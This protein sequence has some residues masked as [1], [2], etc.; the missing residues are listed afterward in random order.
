MDV[1]SL[2]LGASRPTRPEDFLELLERSRQG[3]LKVYL[4]Y[5]AGVGKTFRMLQEAHGLKQRGVDVV[6]AYIEPHDRPDT[7]ALVEGLEVVP[8]RTVEFRGVRVEELD[9]DAVLAR[10]PTIAVV[11]ELP[12]TNVPGSRHGKRWEDVLD[13][14]EAGIHVLGAMNV[15]H[16]ESLN[17]LVKETSGVAV[18]ETVP[19]SFL[20]RADQVVN[21]DVAVEELLE[22]VRSGRVYPG[23]DRA[24]RAL[25]AFFRPE[26]LDALREIT[27]REVAEDLHR[28]RE[29]RRR[30]GASEAA[31][32]TSEDRVVV[33]MASAS[34][35]AKALLRR[36]ARLAGRLN[37]TWFVVY[38]AT[39]REDPLTLDAGVQRHLHDHLELARTLGA[40]VVRLEGTDVAAT[41]LE[42]ARAR[43]AR[44]IVIGAGAAASP[45]ARLRELLLGSI[46]DRLIREARGVGIYVMT[47][48]E[49]DA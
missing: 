5:A 37:A 24:A 7:L 23:S 8:R 28:R 49:Q 1:G 15:Q 38:V 25:E 44:L 16:V 42:F 43:A 34:P 30:A 6:L 18:R 22:R 21:V 35:R 36:G 32:V 11:D 45:W 2:D 17:D 9:L 47:W 27:L 46:T 20:W 33:A 31:V 26:N 40:E 4:G 10:R 48:G 3:K 29:G 19:D 41:L 13:L 39:P 12:H 14:L